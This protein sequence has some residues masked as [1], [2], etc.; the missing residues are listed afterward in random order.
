[1]HALIITLALAVPGECEHC[2]AAGMHGGYRAT[3]S[4]PL[5]VYCP[6][7]TP[8]VRWF[9]KPCAGCAGGNC[10][11]CQQPYLG[12]APY[13]Y[14]VQFDYPWSQE[15]AYPLHFHEPHP[16]SEE[17]EIIEES[18]PFDPTAQR[19]KPAINHLRR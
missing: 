17:V 19:S 2:Q 18:L 11:S 8:P 7:Y 14:R 10:L 4:A 16:A 15:P 1:M 12:S 5:A 3:R 13:N 6:N 9:C